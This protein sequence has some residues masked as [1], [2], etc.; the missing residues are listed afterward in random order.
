MHVTPASHAEQVERRVM[1]KEIFTETPAL[2]ERCRDFSADR[3]LDSAETKALLWDDD[4]IRP[5]FPARVDPIV[6]TEKGRVHC[7][8]PQTGVQRDLA[9]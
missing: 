6:H 5:L 2:A 9:F 3:G 7:I 1:L 8:C 4:G